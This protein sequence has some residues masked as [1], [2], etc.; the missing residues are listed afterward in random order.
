MDNENRFGQKKD[1][2]ED[3]H[4]NYVLEGMGL[5]LVLLGIPMGLFV[6]SNLTMGLGFGAAIGCIAGAQI[7]RRKK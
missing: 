4:S 1:T 2:S 3:S 7:K 6:L 5:G